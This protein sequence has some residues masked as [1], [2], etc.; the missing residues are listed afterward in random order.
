MP[1]TV[2]DRE[3]ERYFLSPS[4]ATAAI[5]SHGG[6]NWRASLI[7]ECGGAIL[8]AD[9]ARYIA[10]NFGVAD[11][12]LEFIGLRPGVQD[13]RGVAG[14]WRGRRGGPSRGHAGGEEPCADS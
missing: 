6:P 1:M 5:S 13:A 9:L 7:P 2:T 8:I 12:Q 4:E 11:P 14:K 3:A 10:R